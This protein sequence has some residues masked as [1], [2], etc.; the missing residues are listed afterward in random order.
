MADEPGGAAGE[1]TEKAA[2]KAAGLVAGAAGQSV[3][4]PAPIA[5]KLGEEAVKQRGKALPLLI[6]CAALAIAPLILLIAGLGAIIGPF[7]G[8]GSPGG[9]GL[10]GG[11]AGGVAAFADDCSRST[12]LNPADL[13]RIA[14]LRPIYERAALKHNVPWEALAAIH[15][16]EGSNSLTHSVIS[17]RAIGTPEPDQGNKVYASFE[18]TAVDGARILKAKSGGKLTADTVD[19]A[20][21]KDAFFGYNGRAGIYKDQAASLGYDRNKEGY[22][23]SPYVMNNFD[24]KHQGLRLI[25]HDHG[26]LNGPDR[27]D[28]A[29]KI[30]VGLKKLAGCP[31]TGAQGTAPPL[32]KVPAVQTELVKALLA[33]PNITWVCGRTDARQDIRAG[34]VDPRLLRALLIAAESGF[35]FRACPMKSGHR[36]CVDRPDTIGKDPSICPSLGKPVSRH[37]FGLAVDIAI[38]N[39]KAV[40]PSNSAAV[41][42]SRLLAESSP[43][44]RELLGP[45][46][47]GG[48]ET[49]SAHKNHIHLAMPR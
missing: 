13:S 17:G 48:V 22:E 18:E 44:G 14:R 38:V 29:Y 37:A 2:E 45:V 24:E 5:K 46:K 32:P 8:P 40:S 3:G 33:H 23:G 39:G 20:I 28:G 9:S 21:T 43:P 19:P 30:F 6:G 41:A 35:R 4:I 7:F 31:P 15:Y 16:R 49:N 1:L 27:R 25:K 47:G 12:G 10:P 26:G 42:L 11:T 36:A 34:L